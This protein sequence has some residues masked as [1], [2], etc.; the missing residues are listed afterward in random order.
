MT[1]EASLRN[2]DLSIV[3]RGLMKSGE[4]WRSVIGQ[5]KSMNEVW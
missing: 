1:Q 2:E 5:K 3:M 4:W